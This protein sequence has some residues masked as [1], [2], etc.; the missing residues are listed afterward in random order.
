[1]RCE[2]KILEDQIED[3]KK[4]QQEEISEEDI[5]KMTQMEIENQEL[6]LQIEAGEETII[7]QEKQIAELDMQ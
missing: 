2:A 1:M 7:D 6:Q 3:I 5:K 4:N